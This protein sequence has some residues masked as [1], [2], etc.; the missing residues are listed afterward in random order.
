MEPLHPLKAT[1]RLATAESLLAP[2]LSLLR[3]ALRDLNST[4]IS[5]FPTPAHK[6]ERRES[7]LTRKETHLGE[8]FSLE[9]RQQPCNRRRV[10]DLVSH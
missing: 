8:P 5:L 7:S 9:Q 4:E 1:G 6:G 3:R 10:Q 2:G